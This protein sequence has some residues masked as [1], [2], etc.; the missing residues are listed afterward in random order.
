MPYTRAL[1]GA[2]PVLDRQPHTLLPVIPGQPPDLARLPEGCAFRPRC[3]SAGDRCAQP[4][5][6]DEHEPGHWWACW[7]PVT[8]DEEASS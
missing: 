8:D 2:I 7:H 6:F 4:P 1:L 5:P 3:S